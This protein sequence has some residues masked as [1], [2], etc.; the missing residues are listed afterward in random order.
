MKPDLILLNHLF[1]NIPFIE[2]IEIDNWNEEIYTFNGKRYIKYEDYDMYLKV[3]RD[4]K[5]KKIK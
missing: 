2:V 5:F 1:D 3:S 4:K